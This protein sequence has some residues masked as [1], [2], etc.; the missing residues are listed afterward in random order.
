MV[1]LAKG[2]GKGQ[3]VKGKRLLHHEKNLARAAGGL[4]LGGGSH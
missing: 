4:A 2:N 3:R 1:R